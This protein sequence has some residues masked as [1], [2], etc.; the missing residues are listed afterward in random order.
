MR[1]STMQR[2]ST[3][4]VDVVRPRRSHPVVRLFARDKKDVIRQ[5]LSLNDAQRMALHVC[6]HF[7]TVHR[8]HGVR[9]SSR[10]S[11]SA[12]LSSVPWPFSSSDILP[13]NVTAAHCR[14]AETRTS[15]YVVRG[16]PASRPHAFCSCWLVGV[17]TLTR[18]QVG[19]LLISTWIGVRNVLG[20]VLRAF[21]GR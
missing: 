16:A 12:P 18:I 21:A 1:A 8:K 7:S 13:C 19:P 4:I 11:G 14:S 9:P 5:F 20:A 6:T 2:A 17:R 15:G 10:V 3:S